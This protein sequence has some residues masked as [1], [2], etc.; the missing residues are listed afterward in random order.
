MIDLFDRP[1]PVSVSARNNC[2]SVKPPIANPPICKKERREMPSQSRCRAPSILNMAS[3]LEGC[4]RSTIEPQPFIT[5][6]P[7]YS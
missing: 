2:G 6:F 1:T 5:D 3:I 4:S 7:S